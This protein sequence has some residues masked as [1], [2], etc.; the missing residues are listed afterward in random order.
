MSNKS[1]L[2]RKANK[3]AGARLPLPGQSHNRETSLRAELS[4]YFVPDGP[5]EIIWVADI[6][7]CMASIEV[8]R[9]QIA[10]FR[11]IKLKQA[12]RDLIEP[13]DFFDEV[14]PGE[15]LS[16]GKPDDWGRYDGLAEAGFIPPWNETFLDNPAFA[17]LL[18]AISGQD[19]G[20]LRLLEQMLVD[21]AKERDRIINQI[22]RRRR[23]AMRD[24]IE[25]AEA[26][27]RAEREGKAEGHA[28]VIDG[29]SLD[30]AVHEGLTDMLADEDMDEDAGADDTAVAIQAMQGHL[31]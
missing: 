16:K 23:Q 7:Y 5:V 17:E 20:R 25:Q 24:A 8:I 6:A 15:G 26:R 19:A 22:D 31:P 28:A 10:G 9:V 2:T 18:G 12:Y 14:L 21:Q 29:N 27:H 13:N 30:L 11:M 3:L 1:A 4:D